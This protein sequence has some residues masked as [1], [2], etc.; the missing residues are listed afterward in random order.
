M[1]PVNVAGLSGVVDLCS[2]LHHSCARLTDNSLR[3]WGYN[4]SGEL[5]D[6]TRVDRSSPVVGPSFT[7]IASLSCGGFPNCVRHPDGTVECWGGGSYGQLG[8]GSTPASS[9]AVTVTGL[10]GVVELDLGEDHSCARL[11]DGTMR[12]WGYDAQGEIGDGTS[13][14]IRPLPVFVGGLAGATQIT[15]GRSATCAVLADMTAR[16]WGLN[17]FGQVGDGTMGTNRLVPTAVVGLTG[18]LE[19][20]SGNSHTCARVADSTVRCWG[21]AGTIGDGTT[22]SARTTPTAVVGLGPVLEV[23]AGN[24]HTCARLAD[25]SVRCWGDNSQGQCGDGTSGAPR[26]TPVMVVGLP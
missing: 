21:V 11:S 20:D 6:G 19:I 22:A 4:G 13:G 26:S 24:V 16:C 3:C 9:S 5:G 15:A 1:T 17:N 23:V 25:G 12:C 14:T 10:S 2:G 18:V 7:N 8:N